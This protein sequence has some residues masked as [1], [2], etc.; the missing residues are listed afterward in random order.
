MAVG[1]RLDIGGCFLGGLGLQMVAC[2]W[3]ESDNKKESAGTG[4]PAWAGARWGRVIATNPK[5][6]V[7]ATNPK[8]TQSHLQAT[9]KVSQTTPKPTPKHLKQT[10]NTSPTAPQNLANTKPKPIPNQTKTQ[11][12]PKPTQNPPKRLQSSGFGVCCGDSP[13]SAPWHKDNGMAK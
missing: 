11:T 4:S 13:C 9:R 10:A 2:G 7:I 6:T 3:Q 5:P 1:W 8:P 12:N